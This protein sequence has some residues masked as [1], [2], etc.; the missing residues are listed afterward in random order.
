MEDGHMC[1]KIMEKHTHVKLRNVPSNSRTQREVLMKEVKICPFP[2]ALCSEAPSPS[3]H[4]TKIAYTTVV[5]G[6]SALDVSS[7]PNCNMNSCD[8]VFMWVGQ[9]PWAN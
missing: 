6:P 4:A 7:V 9:I 3:V 1:I 8:H 5:S 2:C